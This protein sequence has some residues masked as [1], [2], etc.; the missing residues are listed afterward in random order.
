[1][2][3]MRWGVSAVLL[4]LL[5]AGCGS[6]SPARTGDGLTGMDADF[7]VCATTP[8]VAVVPGISVTSASHAYTATLQSATTSDG[9]GGAPLPTATVGYGTFTIAVTPNADAG[10]TASTDGLTMSVPTDVQG[11]PFMPAPHNHGGATIPAITPLGGGTFTVGNLDFFMAG[12]WQLYLDLQAAPGGAK[13][14]V[15]FDLCIPSD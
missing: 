1:M 5:A 12:W 15:T 14:R 4:A 7:S 10:T 6:G 8:A 9:R 13:D 2:E 11:D 3:G